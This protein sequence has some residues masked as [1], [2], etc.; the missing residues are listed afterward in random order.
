MARLLLHP[1]SNFA[2]IL[3]LCVGIGVT[4]LLLNHSHFCSAPQAAE[5]PSTSGYIGALPLLW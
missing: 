5:I 1:W 2:L 3:A 4:V